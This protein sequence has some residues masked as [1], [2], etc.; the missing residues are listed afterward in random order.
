MQSAQTLTPA[1]SKAIPALALLLGV[2]LFIVW[3]M[4]AFDV[5]LMK[6]GWESLVSQPCIRL[7]T[8]AVICGREEIDAMCAAWSNTA[9]FCTP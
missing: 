2:G 9:N 7:I 6:L 1:P 4:G 5:V 8:D 3:S